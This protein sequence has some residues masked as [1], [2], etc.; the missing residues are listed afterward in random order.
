MMFAQSVSFLNITE[1]IFSMKGEPCGENI[2]IY[3]FFNV[4]IDCCGAVSIAP[5][6]FYCEGNGLGPALINISAAG[7]LK[8]RQNAVIGCNTDHCTIQLVTPKVS[9]CGCELVSG[10][11][12]VCWGAKSV[13]NKLCLIRFNRN[14]ICVAFF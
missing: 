1:P 3:I 11:M 4:H 13:C 6:Y 8:W 7:K 12:S 14:F 10:Q 2:Y 9:L 5:N